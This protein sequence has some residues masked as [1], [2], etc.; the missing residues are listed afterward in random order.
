LQTQPTRPKLIN[1]V[2]RP[3]IIAVTAMCAEFIICGWYRDDTAHLVPRL[4]RTMEAYGL[5]H[6]FVRITDKRSATVI[7]PEQALQAMN[8][9]P[10]NVVV[11]LDAGA[12]INTTVDELRYVNG[13]VGLYMR[14]KRARGRGGTRYAVRSGTVVLR[15]NRAARR[16]VQLW[17]EATESPTN[18][19]DQSPLAVAVSRAQGIS[20]QQLHPRFC[21]VPADGI[22]FANVMHGAFDGMG[23]PKWWERLLEWL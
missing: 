7:R 1:G 11:L 9:N 13:D 2:R 4:T 12:T 17:I 10:G 18:R 16:F 15:P 20:I 19:L 6:D 22:A 23:K 8:R 14:I 21:A 5:R 3:G